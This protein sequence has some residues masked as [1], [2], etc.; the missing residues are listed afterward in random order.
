MKNLNENLKY[1][2]ENY[3][4]IVKFTTIT[5]VILFLTCILL[6]RSSLILHIIP[7]TLIISMYV[8]LKDHA[9][10]D[11]DKNLSLLL[12]KVSSV[13]FLLG[14]INTGILS[15]ANKLAAINPSIV[16]TSV[17]LIFLVDILIILVSLAALMSEPI[18]EKINNFHNTSTKALFSGE[19]EE[20]EIKPGDAVIGYTLEDNKPVILPLKDRYLHMLIIG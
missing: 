19:E 12:A 17:V 1:F 3:I 15:V 4:S 5:Q 6:K 9:K 16:K 20:E 11:T 10:S 13:L 14:I 8:I 7:F 2:S 18:N